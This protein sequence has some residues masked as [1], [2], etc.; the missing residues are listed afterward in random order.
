MNHQRFKIAQHG[1]GSCNAGWVIL[2]YFRGCVFKLRMPSTLTPPRAGRSSSSAAAAVV[3]ARHG[4]G[5]NTGLPGHSQWENWKCGQR[6]TLVGGY[7]AC[8]GWPDSSQA[9]GKIGLVSTEQSAGPQW[10]R[11]H[12]QGVRYN[13]HTHTLDHG[14]GDEGQFLAVTSDQRWHQQRE[15]RGVRSVVWETSW[16]HDDVMVGGRWL[17]RI[18]GWWRGEEMS[19]DR[20]R[21]MMWCRV[22]I[23]TGTLRST[24]SWH[25]SSRGLGTCCPLVP[26]KVP[27]EG[28]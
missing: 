1:P 19:W 16:K 12:T 23:W 17:L 22:L 2:R 6:G 18:S 9:P 26:Q 25:Q 24:D 27:S 10:S 5:S 14:G 4:A 8:A 20:R 11:H 13:Q 7:L 15:G 21:V 3:S 28:S